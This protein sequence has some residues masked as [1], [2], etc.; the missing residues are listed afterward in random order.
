LD[1]AKTSNNERVLIIGATNLPKELDDAVRRRFVKR[2][3]IPLPNNE[4]RAQLI[5]T[6]TNNSAFYLKEEDARSLAL[7]TKGF[8]GADLYN[9]CS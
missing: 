4:G 1:G 5:K 2:L 8:S 6:L 9:L 3:Y 7:K